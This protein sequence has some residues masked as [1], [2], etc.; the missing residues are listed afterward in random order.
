MGVSGTCR[1]RPFAVLVGSVL[2]SVTPA[3]A[4]VHHRMYKF[5]R[6]VMDTRLRGYDGGVEY[7]VRIPANHLPYG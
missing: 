4:G 7:E 6:R 5:N 1:S 2:E 3:Q